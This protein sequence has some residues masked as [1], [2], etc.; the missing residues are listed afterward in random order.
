MTAHLYT[1]E[2]FVPEDDGP[3]VDDV[4]PCESADEFGPAPDAEAPNNGGPSNDAGPKEAKRPLFRPIA[5]DEVEIGREPE[6]LIDGLIPARGLFSVVGAPK[7]GKSFLLSDMLFHVA[8][9]APYAGRAVLG[10]L[11]IYLT[12]EGVKGFRRRMVAMR[13]H[14]E[15]EGQGVPFY[16]VENVPDLGSPQTNLP[17]LLA[18]LDQLI[19]RLGLG[20]VRAIA[21]DTIARCMGEGDE[22]SARDMGRFVTRCGEIERHFECVVGTVHH[23]GKDPTKGARGSNALGGAV[24]VTMQVEKGQGSSTVS[25]TEMKDGPEGQ[26]WRF[27]LVPYQFERNISDPTETFAD[28]STCIVELLSEPAR[29]KHAETKSAKPPK[30]VAGDLLK[31]IRRTIDECGEHN[32]DSA[33]VPPN[34]R[35]AS[36]INLKNF[37]KAMDWQDATGKPDAFRSDLSRYLSGLRASGFIGFTQDWVWLT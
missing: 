8:R 5:I 36:R 37:C 12:G 19:A 26:E 14:Y 21:L 4:P 17:A 27:R 15:V 33:A 20:P 3:P 18:E 13:R 1:V 11:V 23:L 24:D 35:A 7:S 10:G 2:R 25:I 32:P 31:V 16:I 6:C 30:G 28:V 29:A 9:N 34:V 22:N